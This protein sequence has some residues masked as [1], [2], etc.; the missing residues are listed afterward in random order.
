MASFSLLAVSCQEEIAYTPGE[1]DLDGCH[2]VYFP[3]QEASG[4][5]TMDPSETPAVDIVVKRL[6]EDGDI[7]VPVEVIASEEGIFNVP[8]LNFADGQTEATLHVTFPN[9]KAGV[10]Y[11][12]TLQV[13]DPE[14]ASQYGANP[15]FITYN[16]IIEKYELMGKALYREDLLTALFGIDN[17]EWEVEVYT[18]ETKPGWYYLSNVYH[19]SVCPLF[20]EGEGSFDEVYMAIDASNPQKVVFPFQYLGWDI[21]YGQAGAASLAPEA[22]LNVSEGVYGTLINGVITFPVEGLVFGMEGYNDFGLYYANSKGMFRICLPGAVLTDY[23][24]AM[25]AGFASEGQQ[26]V[27]FTFGADVETIKYAAYAG[28]LSKAEVEEKV[29]EVLEST[30]AA[31]VS[32]SAADENGNAY[33]NLSF[34]KTGVYTVVAVGYDKDKTAQSTASLA[35]EYVAAGDEVP[36]VVSAGLGSAAKYAPQGISTETALEFYVYGKDLVDV[37]IG[38]FAFADLVADYQ[39]CVNALLAGASAPAEVL[40]Q[41]NTDVYVSVMTGLLPGTD[42]YL[43]AWASNGYEHK[44]IMTE[45][46]KTDGVPKPIYQTFTTD[47]I[48]EELIPSSSE[49]YFGTYNYY[50]RDIDEN[51]SLVPLREYRGQV[52]ISDSQIPDSEP[53]DYGVVSEYCNV[54][55]IIY[56]AAQAGIKTNLTFEYYDGVLYTHG[57]PL[58]LYANTYYTY[59]YHMDNDTGKLYNASLLGAFVDEGYLAFVNAFASQ[60][61][62]INGLY[63]A[64]FSDENCTQFL[65]G[66]DA[67]VDILLVDPAVDDNGLAPAKAAAH[68]TMSSLDL[69]NLSFDI[70]NKV[71]YVETE[72]GRIHS[73]IDAALA[74]KKA[75]KS[76]GTMAGIKGEWDAPAVEFTAVE[77]EPVFMTTTT[78]FTKVKDAAPALY[79]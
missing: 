17:I 59:L 49:G 4:D 1:P 79:R 27:Q 31:T 20:G 50:V 62:N 21:G 25:K 16:V 32:R 18:K 58:G 69:N 57:E 40:Q 11:S 60:G 76:V 75:P 71:N 2:G 35:I 37:K 38:L 68:K 46:F 72:R 70:A 8:E 10:D 39:G 47:D 52:T 28:N 43:L 24:V 33:V 13:T 53:D 65:G 26:P 66:L 44:T 54:E 30:T 67:F 63:L 41:I 36:V 45:P 74:E 77:A 64:A 51:G 7:T 5:H 34:D 73:L 22:G 6:T 55:G 3:T 12:L 9:A 14:Y 23:T 19:P 78:D 29:A 42:Y 61:V 56:Y 15:T 48:D